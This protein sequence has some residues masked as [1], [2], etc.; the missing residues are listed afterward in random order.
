MDTVPARS[1]RAWWALAAAPL[2]W[3]G[4]SVQ[5]AEGLELTDLEVSTLPG[6]RVVLTMVTNGPAPEPL[7]FTIEDRPG[8][9]WISRA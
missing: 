2:L 4:L 5:A 7:S 1:R 3:L 9:P 6:N 8:S